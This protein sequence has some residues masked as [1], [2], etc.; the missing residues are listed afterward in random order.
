MYLVHYV[1]HISLHASNTIYSLHLLMFLG[2]L[3]VVPALRG[4]SGGV[5]GESWL[6]NVSVFL[7][8]LGNVKKGFLFENCN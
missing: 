3:V 2:C 6:V 7:S 1:L 5:L 4:N 8:T